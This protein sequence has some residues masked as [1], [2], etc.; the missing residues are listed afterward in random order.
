MMSNSK[1]KSAQISVLPSD[2]NINNAIV[3]ANPEEKKSNS[4]KE[5]SLEEFE[6]LEKI[7]EAKMQFKRPLKR[8]LIS[9]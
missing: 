3:N 2:S 1:S 7:G 5:R 4:F 8:L 9:I 6:C